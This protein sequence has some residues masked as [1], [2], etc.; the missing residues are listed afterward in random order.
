LLDEP[1]AHLDAALRHDLTATI[2]RMSRKTR[3]AM[4]IVAHA[5]D[6]LAGAA[7]RILRLEE[8]RLETR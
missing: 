3:A 4:L 1:L 5:P 2:R 8:G 6:D 7:D